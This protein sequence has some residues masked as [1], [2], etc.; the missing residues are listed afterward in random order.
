MLKAMFKEIQARLGDEYGLFDEF[1]AQPWSVDEYRKMY[2]NLAVLYIDNGDLQSIPDGAF[3]VISYRLDLFMKVPETYNTSEPV[4]LPIQEFAQNATGV[5]FTENGSEP[6]QY[7]LNC[8]MP[9]STG[10]LIES[11]DCNYIPYSMEIEVVFVRGAS[12]SSATPVRIVLPGSNEAVTLKGVV[13]F[14]E[15]PQADTETNVFVNAATIDGET[16]E[17]M[18]NET[19]VVAKGWNA[20]VVKLFRPQDAS[21]QYLYNV[22]FNTPST[23]VTV[24]VE[25]PATGTLTQRNVV[26]H[27]CSMANVVGQAIYFTIGMSQGMRKV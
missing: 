8:R 12:M 20:Q 26:L 2:K 6:T 24:Q 16:Y 11:G 9:T 10:E 5:V 15:A 21:D 7:V 3:M 25:N 19:M 14:T 1:N 23:Q 17:A 4:V 13:S 27:N 18:T 22:A